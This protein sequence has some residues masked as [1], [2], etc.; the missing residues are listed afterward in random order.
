MAKQKILNKLRDQLFG[1]EDI[2]IFILT[3]V[4]GFSRGLTVVCAHTRIRTTVINVLVVVDCT[5]AWNYLSDCGGLLG[6]WLGCSMLTLGEF[7]ELLMD[8]CVLG[9]CRL[10]RVGHMAPPSRPTGPRPGSSRL[11]GSRPA[12]HSRLSC[13]SPSNSSESTYQENGAAGQQPPQSARS[14]SGIEYR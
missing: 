8:L 11:T 4:L 6:L 9:V 3:A 12:S 5:Q 10:L 13:P 2:R 1:L 7:F 14:V